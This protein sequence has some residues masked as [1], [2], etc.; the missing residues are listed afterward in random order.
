MDV[1]KTTE[2]LDLFDAPTVKARNPEFGNYVQLLLCDGYHKPRSGTDHVTTKGLKGEKSDIAG[3]EVEEYV[4]E[5]IGNLYGA[6][7]T[8]G[9]VTLGKGAGMPCFQCPHSMISQGVCACPECD[10]TLVQ[11]DPVSAPKWRLYC[12]MCNC[13]VSLPEGAHRISTTKDHCPNCDSTILEVDE[14]T[15]HVG[16]FCAMNCCIRSWR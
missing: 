7:K 4:F 6:A 16:A 11:L 15:L 9:G 5:G 1:I 3:I 8:A 14:G 12:N 13:L 10:G 2:P